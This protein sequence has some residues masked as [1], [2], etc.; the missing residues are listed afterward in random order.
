MTLAK[1]GEELDISEIYK[2]R[3]YHRRNGAEPSDA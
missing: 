2:E 3:R 1:G